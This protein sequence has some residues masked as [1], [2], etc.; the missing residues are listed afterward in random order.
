M[1]LTEPKVQVLLGLDNSVSNTIVQ[2][3]NRIP[4]IIKK[5]RLLR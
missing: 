2:Y 5:G 3:V 1:I 4:P